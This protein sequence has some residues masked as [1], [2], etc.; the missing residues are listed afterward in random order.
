MVYRDLMIGGDFLTKYLSLDGDA[1]EA[2][3]IDLNKRL[4]QREKD[5]KS[6]NDKVEEF[7]QNPCGPHPIWSIEP[8]AMLARKNTRVVLMISEKP[9]A[10]L[11]K[12]C[13]KKYQCF[14]W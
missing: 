6:L 5:A 4:D 2:A 8:L 9:D 7:L 11:S 1:R 10:T 13:N 3:A 12:R 14:N